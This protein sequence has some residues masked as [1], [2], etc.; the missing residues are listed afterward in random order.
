MNQVKV[1]RI[2]AGSYQA[3][4]DGLKFNIY[5]LYCESKPQWILENSHEVE[6]YCFE[7][8]NH[9]IEALQHW[10]IDDIKQKSSEGYNSNNY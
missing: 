10:S 6:V 9:A 8:K 7:F 2:R 4:V 3:I 5:S 1:K